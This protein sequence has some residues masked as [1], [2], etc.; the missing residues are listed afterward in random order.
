MNILILPVKEDEDISVT[1]NKKK[2]ICDLIKK[3]IQELTYPQLHTEV[4]FLEVLCVLLLNWLHALLQM[5]SIYRTTLALNY[6]RPDQTSSNFLW[7]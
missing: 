2:N 7:V 6:A 5:L 1:L 3:K 4:S